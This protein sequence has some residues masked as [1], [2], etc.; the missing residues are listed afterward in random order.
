MFLIALWCDVSH[1]N[2]VAPVQIANGQVVTTRNT[3]ETAPWVPKPRKDGVQHAPCKSRS[4]RDDRAEGE[5]T[6]MGLLRR[7]VALLCELLQFV[8]A[9]ERRQRTDRRRVGTA[10]R[11]L[12]T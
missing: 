6:W 2:F 5:S 1:S 9:V 11:T 3:C 7:D 8:A 12:A 4:Q 10:L